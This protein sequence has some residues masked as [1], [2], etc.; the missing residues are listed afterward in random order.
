MRI[1]LGSNALYYPAHGGGERSNQMVMEGLAARGHVCFVITRIDRFGAEGEEEFRT[2]LA[3]R[4]VEAESE[5]G[6]LRFRLKGVDVL[7]AT[8]TAS[9]RAFFVEHKNLFRPD[10]IITSTDDPAQI[11]LE[12]ALH[13]ERAPTVFLTRATIALP[14]GPDAAFPSRDKTELLHYADT[15]VG[16]S[17]YVAGYIR[18]HSGIEAIHIPIAPVEPGPYPRLGRFDNDFVTMVN[19]CAVKGITIFIELARSLPHLRFAGVPTWG[20]TPDDIA[21]L[22]PL[23][24]ITVL[25]KVDQVG[26]LLRRTRV[27]LAPSVWA[28]ARSR[29]VVEAML[30]G[31]PVMASNLGGL[32]EAKMGVPYILPV[33]PLQSYSPRLDEQF[34]PVAD[35]PAQDISP[36][37]DALS[38]LTQ[39]RAHWQEI[40]EQSHAAALHYAETATVDAFA[41]YLQQLKRK[42]HRFMSKR[43]AMPSEQLAKLSP[44][45]RKLL[46][47]KLRNKK[48]ETVAGS[49]L[50]MGGTEASRFRLFCFPHAG[51][52]ASFFRSWR[53][54][55]KD[56]GEV[57]P[58]QYPGREN[59]R[60]EAF[61]ISMGDLVQEILAELRPFVSAGDYGFF[62]HSMGAIVAF[63]LA[64]A[65]RRGGLQLPRLLIVSAARAPQF[66]RDHIPPPDPTRQELLDE[67]HRL[68]GLPEDLL[69]NNELLDLLLP[70]LE[71]DTSLYRRYVYHPGVPLEIP[72]IAAGG[73]D[74]PNVTE[75]HLTA[76]RQ[77]TSSAF[78]WKQFSGGH[79]YLRQNEAGFLEFLKTALQVEPPRT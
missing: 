64:R 69:S 77:Q 78:R 25:P 5:D 57:A 58:V 31:V 37:I 28:E 40:S 23:A 42:P 59:R 13:D 11:L 16:V 21:A 63:E 68:E 50:P 33:R 48:N 51:G 29:I 67:V 54:P 22:G 24:N 44:E 75:I 9:F 10:V 45:R 19:P 6:A 18:Q 66:R 36:W 27:L 15:I 70:A 8:T 49:V 74:D 71:A 46:E 73:T 56:V 62:G 34:V 60:A 52:S 4:G 41:E 72:I 20:T 32:P 26:E 61:A 65:L 47:L 55:F 43:V 3:K 39:D 76:W 30:A 14:F 38:Q 1:L 79:F 12:A 17:E 35:V 53:E 7:A 2:S